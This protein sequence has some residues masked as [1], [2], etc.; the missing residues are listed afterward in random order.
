MDAGFILKV[1][2][3][4]R[5]IPLRFQLEV[6]AMPPLLRGLQSPS[7]DDYD[8][9]FKRLVSDIFEVSRK[10]PLGSP[11]P[12]VLSEIEVSH[13]LST[14]AAKIAVELLKR[15]EAGRHGDPELEV[16][17]LLNATDLLEDD[18]AEGVEELESRGLVETLGAL[19]YS[20]GYFAIVP[21]SRLFAEFDSETT[22][23]NPSEDA[24]R[25]AADLV[26]KEGQMYVPKWAEEVGWQARRINPALTYLMERDLV[27]HSNEVSWP[28]ISN[29]VWKN[30]RTRRFVREST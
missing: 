25:L 21:T 5:F 17:E 24:V 19:G 3:K 14:S 18:I 6:N 2:G 28:F 1:E 4:S 30:A 13:G 7:L 22:E 16:E 26:N 9:D 12:F 15:S 8:A 20:L 27:E 23:W 10:P 29:H 11:P